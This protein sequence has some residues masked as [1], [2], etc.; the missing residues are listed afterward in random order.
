MSV[1]G[2]VKFGDWISEGWNLFR[3]DWRT[4]SV[5]AL[6]L[7]APIL[8]A[9]VILAAV[10]IGLISQFQGISS[11]GVAALVVGG[12]FLMLALGYYASLV[13]AGMFRAAFRQ[14][15][16]EDIRVSDVWSGGDVA[17]QVLGG[18]VVVMLLT[19]VGALLCYLPALIVGGLTYFTI[20]LIVRR[21]RSIMEAVSD[22]YQVTK[23]DWF[24]FTLFALV[25]GL[26]AQVG[27][28]A[29]YIGIVFTL[30]LLFTIGAVAYRDC[31]EPELRS[32]SPSDP[33]SFKTCRVCG[34]SIPSRAAF[35]D[36]CG[37]GQV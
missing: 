35:C 3:K 12:L 37:S 32:R 26:L 11:E 29:C 14:L 33:P 5:M 23:K 17:I 15:E 6:M 27:A 34:A 8:V 4:W 9:I 13:S 18:N 2:T 21:R 25:I 36:R 10:L 16:G 20:P 28:Y 22:S 7:F 31:F 1:G 19:L 24:M 30:P